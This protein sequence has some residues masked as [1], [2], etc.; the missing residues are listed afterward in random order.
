MARFGDPLWLAATVLAVLNF[1]SLSWGAKG[2]FVAAEGVP[3]GMRLLG[4]LTLA[5]F[6]WFLLARLAWAA[7]HHPGH[8]V[9][10]A[11]GLVLLSLEIAL[12]W[13]AVRATRVRRLTLA[14]S[15]DRPGFLH[16]SGPYAWVRHPFYISYV[17]F[18]IATALLSPG[19]AHWLVPAVMTAV[20][21]GAA[22][23]EEAKFAASD[24]AAAYERYKSRT[25]LLSRM[26]GA[27][28]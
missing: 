10:D 13:W 11:A 5:G 18:W 7:S 8:P 3:R 22:R 23:M 2:H 1:A 15:A 17:L 9:R 16:E 12:F 27:T 24:L 20:Y 26:R 21:V 14:F 6:A 19:W 4:I 28:E 25:A